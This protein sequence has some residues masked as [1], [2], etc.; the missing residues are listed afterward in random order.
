MIRKLKAQIFPKGARRFL[1][2]YKSIL[3]HRV[4]QTK[5]VEDL[6]ALGISKGDFLCIHSSMSRCGFVFGGAET[7]V[8]SFQEIVDIDGTLMVPTFTGGNSTLG[9]VK[10]NPPPFDV[11]L[12]S[13][14]TGR[15]NE[16]FRQM[17][18][19]VRSYHPTHSVSSWGRLAKDLVNDHHLSK[20][21]FGKNT[22][23]AKLIENRGK[24]VLINVNANSLVHY[25]QEIVD[26]PGHYLEDEFSL[27]INL[28]SRTVN[29]LTKVHA[30][31]SGFIKLPGEDPNTSVNIHFPDYALPFCL[32]DT[33]RQNFEKIDKK[34]KSEL[35]ERYQ[36]FLKSGIVKI[37][38][39][40]YGQAA[41]IKAFE[42]SDKISKDL[43]SYLKKN[44]TYRH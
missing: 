17:P 18:G 28:D 1:N 16:I 39:V 20:T 29:V 44:S 15:I 36:L 8:R 27:P 24:V 40:G 41:V 33:A 21:P 37:E 9:Y 25:V 32:N 12:T 6:R 22:P 26:W 19:A 11:T 35:D 38:S 7:V 2:Y 4:T 3:F 5:L 42:F 23:Y 43:S 30:P 31:G 13:C 14:T 34:I 10:T